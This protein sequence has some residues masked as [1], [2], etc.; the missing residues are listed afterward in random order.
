M[1]YVGGVL[2]AIAL[3]PSAPVLVPELAGG[4][5]AELTDLHDAVARAIAALPPRWVVLGVGPDD[6]V[7][8]PPRAS[9]FAGYGADVRVALSPQDSQAPEAL[10]LCALIAGWI[11][12][13]FSPEAAAEIRVFAAAH[14]ADAAVTRGRDLRA[15]I[16]ESADPVGVLVVADGCHTLTPPAPGGYDPD[17]IPVQAALDDALAAGDTAALTRLPGSVLGRVAYQVL[18]GL[19]ESSPPAPQELYRGA[20]YG[21]GYFVGL[22]RP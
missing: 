15:L 13:R 19:A 20:P 5:A 4:A 3:V 11:R 6:A 14:P 9:T 22:W 21:V 17:S 12:G 18:A 7:I 8:T 2:S 16:D 10:P 1:A